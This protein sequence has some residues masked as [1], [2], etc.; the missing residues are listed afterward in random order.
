MNH[1]YPNLFSPIKIGNVVLKNRI[2]GAPT[3]LM[4]LSPY[5]HLTTEN[6]AYYELKAKGGC[7]VVTLGESIVDRKTGESH[8]RQVRLDDPDILP[9]LANT[10]KAIRRGGALA[11]IELSHS[12]KYAGIASI[13]GDVTGDKLSFGP[14]EEILETGEV[15]HEMDRDMIQ[16]IVDAYGKAGSAPPQALP[17]RNAMPSRTTRF[18]TRVMRRCSPSLP[19]GRCARTFTLRATNRGAG[20]DAPNGCI[21]SSK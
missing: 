20:F 15:V 11:N 13:A 4:S 10:V 1:K 17:C 3:G 12:G 18:W 8:N 9:C 14:S 7:A 16:Y 2:I 21:C 5:G 6:I 19:I